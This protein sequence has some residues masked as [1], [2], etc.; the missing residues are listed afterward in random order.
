MSDPRNKH[1]QRIVDYSTLAGT[2]TS[3]QESSF[4]VGVNG[5]PAR[6]TLTFTSESEFSSNN[7][8]TFFRPNAN[9]RRMVMTPHW[10]NC[11]VAAIDARAQAMYVAEL[12]LGADYFT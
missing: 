8:Q 5:G 1:T 9:L 3:E 10:S 7:S 11:A 6:M 12:T 4:F 2:P